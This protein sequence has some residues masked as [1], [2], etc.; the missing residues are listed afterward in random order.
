MQTPNKEEIFKAI[1]DQEEI[2]KLSQTKS[3]NQNMDV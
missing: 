3:Q 2:E 1:L